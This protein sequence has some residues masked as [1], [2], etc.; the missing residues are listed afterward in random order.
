MTAQ[1]LESLLAAIDRGVR[2]LGTRDHVDLQRWLDVD[3]PTTHQAL[4]VGF[5]SLLA[6]SPREWEAIARLVDRYA[7]GA[8]DAEGRLGVDQRQVFGDTRVVVE[9]A[10]ERQPWWLLGLAAVLVS[11][12]LVVLPRWTEEPSAQVEAGPTQTDVIGLAPPEPPPPA[13]TGPR[14]VPRD[15]ARELPAT[16]PLQ[17]PPWTLLLP[18]AALSLLLMELGVRWTR[19]EGPAIA[20]RREAHRKKNEAAREARRKLSVEQVARGVS[21]DD[22]FEVPAFRP[23][24]PRV[25]EDTA[26]LLGRIGEVSGRG[27]LAVER[28]I[29]RSL[30]AGA[31]VVPAWHD[32]H[33]PRV[34]VVLLDHETLGDHPW[35]RPFERLMAAWSRAGVPLQVYTFQADPE[36]VKDEAGND[37]GLAEVARRTE[38]APLLVLSRTIEPLGYEGP[39]GWV[40][41]LPTWSPKAWVDPD[42]RS[43]E[44][45][46]RAGVPEQLARLGLVRFPWTED[47]LL[48]AAAHL[49]VDARPTGAPPEELPDVGDPAVQDAVALWAQAAAMVP[50]PSWDQLEGFRRM[51]A[52]QPHLPGENT[53]S[54]L[55]AHIAAQPESRGRAIHAHGDQLR[56]AGGLQDRLLDAAAASPAQDFLR[57]VNQVL[58]DQLG[59]KAPDDA[60]SRAVWE[61]RRACYLLRLDPAG[62]KEAWRV[63]LEGP[64]R[65]EGLRWLSRELKRRQEHGE[66]VPIPEALRAWLASEVEEPGEARV[67]DLL[68]PWRA[69]GPPWWARGLAVVGMGALLWAVQAAPA[70]LPGWA[71]VAELPQTW[72]VEVEEPVWRV[73]LG[74]D[75]V[76]EVRVDGEAAGSTPLEL[77]LTAG[78]H[79]VQLL[80]PVGRRSEAQGEVEGV[81]A[82]QLTDDAVSF[83]VDV[84]EGGPLRWCFSFAAAELRA[85]DCPPPPEVV[86]VRLEAD[87]PAAVWVDG[88]RRGMAPLSVDL[89]KGAH[90]VRF[91]ELEAALEARGRGTWCARLA[92]GRVVE[93]ACPALV[94]LVAEGEAEVWVDGRS[95]GAAPAEVRL[96]AGRRRLRFVAVGVVA[97]AAVEVGAR[98]GVWCGRPGAGVVAEGACPP[99]ALATLTLQSDP[100]GVEVWSTA[101]RRGRRR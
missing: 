91:G 23:F 13:T 7:A 38:R 60:L 52:L 96:E 89:A 4:R 34:L 70:R 75:R 16:E 53:V 43:D 61:L 90:T 10:P 9:R 46:L 25:V 85:G 12:E 36:R 97:E 3:P 27:G 1:R 2:P 31:R 8:L 6:R 99:P 47:G 51:E 55:L 73:G 76:A 35:R 68:R 21:P 81:S 62:S 77:E 18:L 83:S 80:G 69:P 14:L 56:L 71:T 66:Q 40:R 48:A 64:L 30:R 86:R 94:R 100:S 19:I 84:Q 98:G 82:L 5:A 59:S 50:E 63:V 45:P 11:A 15:P 88:A 54:L 28:T 32:R 65:E 24:P 79:T 72:R 29:D 22:L 20:A 58:L 92:E 39:R 44:D 41:V 78:A 67:V 26:S 49:A 17:V 37:L 93:G 42:P 74:A 87:G 95:V 33:R 57:E 101:S